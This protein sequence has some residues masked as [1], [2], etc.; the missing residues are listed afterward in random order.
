VKLA[1]F[2]AVCIIT[3]FGIFAGTVWK[4]HQESCKSINRGLTVLTSVITT[5]H[6]SPHRFNDPASVRD[7]DRVYRAQIALIASSRCHW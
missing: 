5:A 7:R 3:A 1:V 2:G 4:T 6:S